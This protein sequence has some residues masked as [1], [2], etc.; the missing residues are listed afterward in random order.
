MG[1]KNVGAGMSQRL[2]VRLSSLTMG[3]RHRNVD[4]SNPGSLDGAIH[5]SGV[6]AFGK[7]RRVGRRASAQVLIRLLDHEEILYSKTHVGDTSPGMRWRASVRNRSAPN[8]GLVLLLLALV[9]KCMD[10]L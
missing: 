8:H 1:L 2:A 9:R 5:K 3:C 7:R 6:A 10:D 4:V